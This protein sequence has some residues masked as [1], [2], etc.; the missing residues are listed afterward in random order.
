MRYGG[1]PEPRFALNTRISQ[2][3]QIFLTSF[4]G[5]K[6]LL[7]CHEAQVFLLHFNFPI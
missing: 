3:K 6:L 4:F 2:L 7:K 1:A 5:P